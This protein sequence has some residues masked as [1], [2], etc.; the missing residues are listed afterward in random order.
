M[1]LDASTLHLAVLIPLE[2]KIFSIILLTHEINAD[3][4]SFFS[5]NHL[6]VLEYKLNFCNLLS[7][8]VFFCDCLETASSIFI[9]LYCEVLNILA[10]TSLISTALLLAIFLGII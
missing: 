7:T 6:L 5:P 8:I 3:V 10:G 9:A 4:K 2:C 1:K